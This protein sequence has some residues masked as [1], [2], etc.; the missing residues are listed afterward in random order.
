MHTARS[1]QSTFL[2]GPPSCASVGPSELFCD[3][4]MEHRLVQAQVGHQLFEL[5]IFLFQQS[6]P[7]ELRWPDLPTCRL[8]LQSGRGVR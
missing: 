2:S 7:F 5:A 6:Q 4:L 1:P 3:Y 8:E